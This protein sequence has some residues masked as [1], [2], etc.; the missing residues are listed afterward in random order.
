[1]LRSKIQA[2]A[3]VG[4]DVEQRKHSCIASGIANLYSLSGNPFGT[5]PENWK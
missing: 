2:T 3:Y 1:M 4:M 5:F